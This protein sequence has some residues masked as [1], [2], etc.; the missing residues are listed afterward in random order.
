MEVKANQF[1][2]AHPNITQHFPHP[3]HLQD[4]IAKGNSHIRKGEDR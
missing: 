1:S 3:L 2:P 4:K